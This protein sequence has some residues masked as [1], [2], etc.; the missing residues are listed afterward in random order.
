[1]ALIQA[2]IPLELHA[3][4]EALEAEIVALARARYRRTGGQAGMVRWG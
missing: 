3:V 4:G 2:L 1:M